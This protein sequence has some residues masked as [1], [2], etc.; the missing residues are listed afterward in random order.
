[1]IPCCEKYGNGEC[2]QFEPY[3]YFNKSSNICDTCIEDCEICQNKT[4]CQKCRFPF[5]FIDEKCKCE[6]FSYCLSNNGKQCNE[7]NE[8]YFKYSPCECKPCINGC[9][10]CSNGNSCNICFPNFQPLMTKNARNEDIILSCEQT[11]NCLKQN[12][13]ELNKCELCDKGFYLDKDSRCIK[14]SLFDKY[15]ESCSGYSECTSCFIQDEITKEN[16]KLKLDNGLCKKE[17]DIKCMV[18]FCIEC[19]ENN[20]NLCNKCKEGYQTKENSQCEFAGKCAIKDPKASEC[21]SC[22]SGY[23]LENGNCLCKELEDK[24]S[25]SCCKI[26]EGCKD[27]RLKFINSIN[28]CGCES[29]KEGFIRTKYDFQCINFNIKYTN[30]YTRIK[31]NLNLKDLGEDCIMNLSSAFTLIYHLNC[32]ID[33]NN[34]PILNDNKN[35]FL[36]SLNTLSYYNYLGYMNINEIKKF[37]CDQTKQSYFIFELNCNVTISE[38]V[39]QKINNFKSLA[40][41]DSIKFSNSTNYEKSKLISDIT[42]AYINLCSSDRGIAF[43]TSPQVRSV[44]INSN[45]TFVDLVNQVCLGGNNCQIKKKYNIDIENFNKCYDCGKNLFFDYEYKKCFSGFISKKES[46]NSLIGIGY[47]VIVIFIL[48]L[49]GLGILYI[50]PPK[51]Y[52]KNGNANN[53]VEENQSFKKNKIVQEQNVK[54][55]NDN[56]DDDNK[57][58][59]NII[60]NYKTKNEKE[61]QRENIS[62]WII[63]FLSILNIFLEVLFILTFIHQYV[64]IKWII[65]SMLF[66][67]PAWFLINGI[68]Y[69]LSVLSKISQEKYCLWIFIKYIFIY[70]FLSWFDI[71]GNNSDPCGFNNI[72]KNIDVS[73]KDDKEKFKFK[74]GLRL[75]KLLKLIGLIIKAIFIYIGHELLIFPIIITIISFL[76]LLPS[77]ISYFNLKKKIKNQLNDNVEKSNESNNNKTDN[78]VKSLD[79]QE[80]NNNNISINKNNNIELGS[81]KK[82]KLENS[83]N[84]KNSNLDYK[85]FG[86]K[87]DFTKH[88][89]L[90]PEFIP[91]LNDD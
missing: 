62:E 3:F 75:L 41:D 80:K 26:M 59:E 19:F 12:L 1:L 77:I 78:I 70:T 88:K 61:I 32:Y 4:S 5:K 27:S 21:K 84:I 30:C 23:S 50:L 67:E 85:S 52:F 13:K 81:E 7:C 83:N 55:N 36:F 68:F 2:T 89:Y 34:Y 15:C 45:A 87:T 47:F 40:N 86:N 53:N 66:I 39:I 35:Y 69:F 79:Q 11:K 43:K 18:D 9:K 29:C 58:E 44:C 49:L 71:L 28:K 14:C 10:F 82:N 20:K 16:L 25:N 33:E 60:N 91:N 64:S 54:E 22:L 76:C 72:L 56:N 73:L 37:L 17:K 6:S 51:I 74:I 24:T 65:L 63:S 90:G 57:N 31:D 42:E 38:Y 8:G 46:R 48:I